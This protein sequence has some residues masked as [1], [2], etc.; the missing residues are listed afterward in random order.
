MSE[1]WPRRHPVFS[2]AALRPF[3]PAAEAAVPEG[4]VLKVLRH[5]PG[6]RVTSLVE[7]GGHR[8]VVK[9]HARPVAG[10]AGEQLRILAR[11]GL[12]GVT[13]Y[14]RAVEA[15]GHVAALT[16][17]PGTLLHELDDRQLLGACVRVGA[18]LRRLHDCRA[19]ISR[20]WTA[21]DELARTRAGAVDDVVPAVEAL[22][23]RAEDLPEQ[24]HVVA[25]RHCRPGHLVVDG[26][27][28]VRL[29]DLDAVA[30]APRGLDVGNLLAHLHRDG[31]RGVRRPAVAAAAGDAFLLGYG[32]APGLDPHTVGWWRSVALLRLARLAQQRRQDGLE[33]DLLLRAATGSP[34]LPLALPA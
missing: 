3:A 10:S 7:A 30:V 19:A 21:D 23:E 15:D 18:A 13:P 1:R 32:Q 4:R 6:H 26:G 12:A 9:V 8:L 31:L 5:V 2:D 16:F 17:H 27:G 22:R 34:G 33:R 11:A 24:D 20:H 14:P 25:H 29:V 28:S